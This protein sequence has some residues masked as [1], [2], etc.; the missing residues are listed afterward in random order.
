MNIGFVVFGT[1]VSMGLLFW[2]FKIV[3]GY[4]SNQKLIKSYKKEIEEDIENLE[5]DLSDIR[6]KEIDNAR[7]LIDREFLESLTKGKISALA[8]KLDIP[9][10]IHKRKAEMVDDFLTGLNSK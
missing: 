2:L 6:A 10:S 3:D 8:E 1:I 4:N 7:K 9:V 5:H